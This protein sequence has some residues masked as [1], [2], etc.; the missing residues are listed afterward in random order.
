MA[1]QQKPDGEIGLFS[2]FTSLLKSETSLPLAE[3]SFRIANHWRYPPSA[4]IYLP[5]LGRPLKSEF[6]DTEI[7][8]VEMTLVS[9]K[10]CDI[11]KKL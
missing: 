6:R 11:T 5:T 9:T 2:N 7:V 10:Q 1:T 3:V 4:G 8:L